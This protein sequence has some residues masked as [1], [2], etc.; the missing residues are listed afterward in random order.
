MASIVSC[1]VT[2][3]KQRQPYTKA[4]RKWRTLPSLLCEANIILVKNLTKT[5]WEET[6]TEGS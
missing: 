2:E 5:R 4:S 1:F 6:G 3:K